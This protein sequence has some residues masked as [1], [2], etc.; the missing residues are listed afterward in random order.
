[1]A[2]FRDGNPTVRDLFNRAQRLAQPVSLTAPAPTGTNVANLATNRAAV[3]L[4]KASRHLMRAERG[5]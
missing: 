5:F 1:M 2:Y 4:L 3:Q